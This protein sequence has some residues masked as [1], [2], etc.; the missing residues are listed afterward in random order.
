MSDFGPITL[1]SRISYL[2][3][4]A[5]QA[6]VYNKT[7]LALHMLCELVGEEVFHRGL[8]EFQEAF[9]F[10]SARTINFV[11]S[12]ERVSG[13][14]LGA[15]FGSW[16]DSHLLPDVRVAQEVI[17]RGEEFVL[18]LRVV[19]ENAAFPFPL[20]ISWSEDGT[21]VRKMVEVSAAN[22]IFEL[23][24]PVRPARIRINPDGLVPGSF[25]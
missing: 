7:A 9:R 19:Q 4:N 2:D 25:R 24:C 11:R 5:Y 20:W 14:D 22:Q 12:M 15:F 21:P 10:R 13:R 3:F 8:R 6:V 17:K 18:R 16:F 23:L 1:G